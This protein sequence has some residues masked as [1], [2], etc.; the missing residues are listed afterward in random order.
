MG[1]AMTNQCQARVWTSGGF[2]SHQCQKLA[3][4]K[5]DGMFYC[6]IHDPI[7]KAKKQKVRDQKWDAEQQQRIDKGM[8]REMEAFLKWDGKLI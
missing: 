6:R 5:R 2:H 1:E 3:K 8:W 7:V 4:V